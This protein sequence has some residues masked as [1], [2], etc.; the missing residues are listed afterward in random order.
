MDGARSPEAHHR[1]SYLARSAGRGG[2][3]HSGCRRHRA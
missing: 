1:R 2:A 3:R